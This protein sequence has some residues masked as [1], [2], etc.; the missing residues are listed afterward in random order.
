[1]NRFLA[2]ILTSSALATAQWLGGRYGPTPGRGRTAVWY[3]RLRKPSFTPPGPVFG[4]VWTGLDGL[5]AYAGY[6]LLTSPPSGRRILGVGLWGLNVLGVA[7]YPWV[8]FGRKRLGEASGVTVGMVASSVGAVIAA[9]GV[10][11]RASR[12]LLPLAVWTTFA[13]LL[14]EEVW[15]RNA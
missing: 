7:G 15:R 5:L 4:A 13:S 9:S 1:M 10:D 2:G 14:Q 6:R 3:A 8:F 12:A 11:Q